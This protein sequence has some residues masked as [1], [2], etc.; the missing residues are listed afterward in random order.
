MPFQQHE[1]LG[2]KPT[3]VQEFSFNKAENVLMIA[4][5]SQ[6]PCVITFDLFIILF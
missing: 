1:N 6:R 5:I 4:L 3:P 2:S